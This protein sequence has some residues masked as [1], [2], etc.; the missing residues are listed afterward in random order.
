MAEWIILMRALVWT[1]CK[2]VDRDGQF[3]PDISLVTD[4]WAFQNL[5]DAVFYDALIWAFQKNPGSTS[6]SKSAGKFLLRKEMKWINVG[7]FSAVP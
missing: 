6:Y 5:S 2:Y 7:H 4:N 1:T 3:N